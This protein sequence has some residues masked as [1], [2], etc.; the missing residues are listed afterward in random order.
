MER[1]VGVE[2]SYSVGVHLLPP[3]V[4]LENVVVRAS[5]GGSPALR[6]RRI[7]V[8]PRLFSLLAG[9]LDAGDV[10]IEAPR[11]RVVV[12]DGK[13]MNVR[14]R[15][16]ASKGPSRPLK[17]APFASLSLTDAAVSL[18]LDGTRI[19]AGPVDLDVFAEPGLAFEVALRVGESRVA[20][21]RTARGESVTDDD[22]LCEVDARVRVEKRQVRVRRLSLVGV[23]D[24]D[25]KA[26]TWGRCALGEADPGRVSVKLSEVRATL[27]GG[28]PVQIDG[29]I[30]A[31]APLAIAGRFAKGPFRGWVSVAAD[32]RW[33]TQQGLPEVHGKISGAGIEMAEY[34]FV[35]DFDGDVEIVGDEVR[36]GTLHATYGHAAVVAEGFTMRPTAAGVPMRVR[37]VDAHGLRFPDLMESNDITNDTIVQ[38]NLDRVAITDFGGTID[39]LKLDGDVY[40]ETTGFEVFDRAY[41][42][43]AR[44]HMIG[45]KEATVRCRFG[46]RPDSVQFMASRATFGSSEVLASVSVGFHNDIWLSVAKGSKLDLA[47]ASPLVDIPMDGSAELDVTMAG[48]ADQAVLTGDLRVEDLVFAGFPIGNIESARVRFKPL[49]LDLFDVRGVK[50]SSRFTVPGARL[51][52][53]SDATLLVDAQVKSDRLDLHDFFA[54]WHFDQDPRFDGLSGRGVADARIQYDMGGKRDKCGTGYLRV[55]GRLGMTAADL[56][57]ESYDSAEARFDYRWM[58]RDASYLGMQLD[59][60]SIT[61]KK[62]TG[63]ILGNVKLTDGANVRAHLVASGVPLSKIT[64]LGDL[65][66]GIDGQANAVVEASGTLDAMVADV[67]ARVGPLRLGRATLPGSQV[68]IHLD[69]VVRPPRTIGKTHCGRPMTAPFD[70]A[71]YAA[72]HPDGEFHAAGQLFGGEVEFTDL[73]VTRQRE[74]TVRGNVMLKNLDLGALAELSPVVALADHRLDGRFTGAIAIEDLPL[75]HAGLAAVTLEAKDLRVGRG[76]FR[77]EL[78]RP[79]RLAVARGRLEATG[80]TI[81]T[82]VPTGERALFDLAGGVDGLGRQPKVDLTLALRPTDLSGFARLVPQA[83]RVAGTLAGQ[84]RVTGVWPRLAE[85]GRFTLDH[86]ELALRGTPL[87][88][89][90]M[91]VAVG[92]DPDG[93]QILNAKAALGGG[94]VEIRG[95]APLRGLELGPLRAAIT[96]RNVTVPALDGVRAAVDADLQLA[97]QPESSDEDAR[98][99]P[100]LTGDV[101][102]RSFRYTR[103]VTMAA[104]IDTLTKRGH[105]TRFESYDPSGDLLELEVRIRAARPL[106]IDN[107]LVEGKLDVAEPG[108][109]LSGTN[110]RFGMRGELDVV[111]GGRI[112]LRRNE[113]EITQGLVR[114]DDDE[115]IAPRVDVTA[116]TDYHRY[117]DALASS[118]SGSGSGA[119]AGSGSGAAASATS[120]GRWRITMHA[121]GDPETL[122]V[123]LSSEPA[124]SK[125]DIF[126]LLT[127]GLTRAELDRAQSAT[128]GGSVALEALGRLTGAD[129]AVTDTIPVID[130][131]KLGSA[132]SSRT[133]R[134]EPTVT[135]G[136]RLAQRIRAYVTSGLTESREVRSNLE[137]RLSPRVSVEGSYDNVNDI[138]SSALGNLGADVRWRLEFQ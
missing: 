27:D 98:A 58:D 82:T 84:V 129:E 15:L 88:L 29:Q 52:F 107:D 109:V 97:W 30:T 32:V 114:F 137:W 94:T 2:A 136:K 1:L 86:G 68:R 8:T 95:G 43:P 60:P 131:F 122:R 14:Y 133:G 16:P 26:G 101:T 57:G 115:R 62:G 66:R 19:D 105:R 23:A 123:D 34:R 128:A 69:P 59:V 111:K 80:V 64:A 63:T 9:R 28:K 31:R 116:V 135:I 78:A 67:E 125:D 61:L 79:A 25:P 76:G 37:K 3:S 134:T 72:D 13:L 117:D 33:D 49:V 47:D 108:L 102:L 44:R 124:L 5:D 138:S 10:E 126:L 50:G 4:V 42:S 91:N 93:I 45:V 18:D 48:K 24:A 120:G 89:T 39:P 74:K 104:D 121:Y 92:I 119:S 7:A 132:Y 46:V 100:K 85:S 11:A 83:D 35:K 70:P 55:D 71:G 17:D 90:D 20:R 99:L 103:K 40:S 75:E 12:R 106:E 127:L 53:D 36:V 21:L 51:D 73:R 38:W 113:F 41:H 118:S 81:A 77:V 6:A 22:V 110:Q 130:E 96:A 56:F 87:T 54:M 65:G 112:R